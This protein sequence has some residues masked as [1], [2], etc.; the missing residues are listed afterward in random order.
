MLRF[1][2]TRWRN[3][4][5]SKRDPTGF[6]FA[7]NSNFLEIPKNFEIDG[8]ENELNILIDYKNNVHFIN[9]EKKLVD[10]FKGDI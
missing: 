9:Q 8:Y 3:Y 6:H 10:I 2:G 7:K 4:T 5:L 1:T